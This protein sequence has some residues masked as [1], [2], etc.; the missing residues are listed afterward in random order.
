MSSAWPV[1]YVLLINTER[2]TQCWNLVLEFIALFNVPLLYLAFEIHGQSFIF[3]FINMFITRTAL[4][5]AL[6]VLSLESGSFK[7]V[8]GLFI[9]VNTF[10]SQY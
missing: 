4:V 3:I 1:L 2:N 7:S 8:L 9:A 5:N 6:M 10:Q